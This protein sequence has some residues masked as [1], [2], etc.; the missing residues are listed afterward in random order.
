MTLA[1]GNLLGAPR[2]EAD[3]A[4]LESAFLETRDFLAL[5]QTDDFNF[6][7]G[8]RGTGKSALF[9]KLAAR[10]KQRGDTLLLTLAPEEHE[11]ADLRGLLLKYGSD[12]V[13]LRRIAKLLWRAEL[14]F[15]VIALRDDHYKRAK[16]HSDA[17]DQCCSSLHLAWGP[18]EAVTR[19]EILRHYA[20]SG[21]DARN[22]PSQIAHDLQLDRLESLVAEVLAKA[23]LR[24]LILCDRLDEGWLPDSVSTATLGGLANVA[25]GLLDKQSAIQVVLFVRDNMF[26]ALAHMD[27]DFSRNI[28]GNTLRLSWTKDSL[29]HLVAE[30]L[31]VALKVPDTEND[32]KVWN[33][34]AQRELR[35]RDGF[36]LC[37]RNTLYR[38]RD[39]L[40]LLNAAYRV[41]GGDKREAIIPADV[42]AGARQISHDR[43]SDLLKEYDN[44][45]PG[46]RFLIDAFRGRSPCAS[47][48]EVL[49]LLQT[50]LETCE[51]SERDTADFA[52]LNTARIAFDAL[53]GVG[54]LGTKDLSSGAFQFCHDGA[55][56]QVAIDSSV[57]TI[58]HPCYWKALGTGE[59]AL[60]ESVIIEVNDEYSPKGGLESDFRTKRIGTV[61]GE[62]QKIQRGHEGEDAFE[63]W[64]LQVVKLLFAGTLTNAQLKPN[65]NAVQRRDV[66][67]TNMASNGFWKRILDDYHC[68]QVIFEAKNFDE[69]GPD[70][71]RQ[72]TSYLTGEYGNFGVIV[73]R[74][75]NEALT[76]VERG[77][78]KEAYHT[79]KKLIMLLPAAMLARAV[80]KV[81]SPKRHDYADNMLQKRMDTF[82]RSYIS[83]K[84][85]R[86]RQP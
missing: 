52:L 25:A 20:K 53:Y 15:R 27:S 86:T 29:F 13:T 5:V 4:M 11:A 75:A 7:V 10:V 23:T 12:Y 81:R 46:L 22:L 72:L 34:F 28:E 6:V 36:E 50:T 26:R 66:V 9:Q 37:L 59:I 35:D 48:A 67:A 8:R 39:I 63:R 14:L 64:M 71:F 79:H 42:E 31:R 78:V 16:L 55:P 21:I 56:A 58:V 83:L 80:G 54:F 38:P 45:L 30:R 47:F 60:P 19:V 49:A 57:T 69:I 77:W 73:T 18:L 65:G 41:A 74:T 85:Q 3:R 1:P 61:I 43:L 40:V 62:L 76:D 33:R 17:L 70:E 84:H 32:S 44:V 51:Y 68:R 2:A 24:V 82:V